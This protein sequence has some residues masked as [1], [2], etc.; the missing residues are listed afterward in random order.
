MEAKMEK[1]QTDFDMLLCNWEMGRKQKRDE[2]VFFYFSY[3]TAPFFFMVNLIE[4]KKNMNYIILY[5]HVLISL[6]FI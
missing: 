1:L 3:S 5:I 4:K 6:G 2:K